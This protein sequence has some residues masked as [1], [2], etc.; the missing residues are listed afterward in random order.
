MRHLV[1]SASPFERSI[2]F[3]RAVRVGS[4]VAVA[5]TAPIAV[6]GGVA[7]PGDVYGQTK[8]CLEITKQAI[9]D[10]GLSLESVIR[11]RIMLTDISRWQEAARAH[12]EFFAAIRGWRQWEGLRQA[13][14]QSLHSGHGRDSSGTIPHGYGY[15]RFDPDSLVLL[16]FSMGKFYTRYGYFWY[17]SVIYDYTRIHPIVFSLDLGI[18]PT[19][20][21]SSVTL[22]NA[23]YNYIV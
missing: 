10:A 23:F 12:G 9:V 4:W 2:G 7:C 15:Q 18:Y 13:K 21:P 20:A 6:G 17:Y 11:T 8:R 16:I 14:P 22:C 3:S 19:V 1:S 5:G